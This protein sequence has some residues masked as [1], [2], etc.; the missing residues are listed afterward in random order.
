MTLAF[1]TIVLRTSSRPPDLTIWAFL[2]N[3]QIIA[4]RNRLWAVRHDDDGFTG[5]LEFAN[6]VVQ[7]QRSVRIQ[8]R[9]R[10]VQNQQDRITIQGTR[11]RDALLLAARQLAVIAFQK[12]V[13]NLFSSSVGH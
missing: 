4:F 7:G 3:H 5:C 13:I 9:V 1:C 8:G 11:Q 2:D 6:S 12:L 10:F